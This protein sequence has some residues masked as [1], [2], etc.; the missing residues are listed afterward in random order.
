MMLHVNFHNFSSMPFVD[1]TRSDPLSAFS[2][3]TKKNCKVVS[4]LAKQFHELPAIIVLP[5]L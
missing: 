5:N 4:I 2:P 1:Q 3:H